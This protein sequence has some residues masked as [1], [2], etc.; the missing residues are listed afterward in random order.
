MSI[1]VQLEKREQLGTKAVRKL[2]R[3]GVVPAVL[4][5]AGA[6]ARSFG[7]SEVAARKL[8]R[9]QKGTSLLDVELPDKE[10]IKA[11][12]QDWRR[13]PVSGRIQHID[14]YQ[15]RMDKP[16]NTDIALE[17]I[18][19]S[20][21]VKDLGGTLVKQLTVLPVECLPKDLVPSLA[22]DISKLATF[23]DYIRVKDLLLPLG[24][25]ARL[26]DEEMVAA[27]AAPRS[28]AELAELAGE[29]KGDVAAV[30][31]ISEKKA[32]E[33]KGEDKVAKGEAGAEAPSDKKAEK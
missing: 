11:L 9:E 15:V 4:Y 5:G 28:E 13:H 20:P 17:F 29:V 23:D 3:E 32:E 25:K 30:E 22:V 26:G 21:A 6:K 1:T 8:L 12:A 7:L 19:D 16:V 18:G 14:F 24:V 31:V 2:R 33:E 27:V 10:T